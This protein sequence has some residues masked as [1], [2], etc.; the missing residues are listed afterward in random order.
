MEMQGVVF[1]FDVDNTLLDND[2]VQADLK[3]HLASEYGPAARDAYWA[4]LEE[5]RQE[6][7]YV[8]YLGALQRFRLT[9]MHNPEV[10][11]MSNWLV[12]YCFADRLYPGAVETVEYVKRR[13]RAVILSDG[14]AV[15][16]PRK[17]ERSGLWHLFDG[18]V[19][20]YVHK[21]DELDN[22]AHFYPARHFFMIDDKLRILAAVKDVWKERVTTVFVRQGH[23]AREIDGSNLYPPADITIEQIRDLINCN[24]RASMERQLNSSSK[25]GP[26]DQI[27]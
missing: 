17:I 10:L 19:L 18:H 20:I 9:A 12:D 23:Y 6:L 27:R 15:F 14:D 13:G 16:Q 11:R 4:I 7:G 3:E 2:Q 24:L 22:V 8:D 1:L 21:E 26:N 5:L 25:N